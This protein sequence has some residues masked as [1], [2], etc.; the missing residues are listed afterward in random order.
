MLLVILT[1]L[2]QKKF[3]D[4]AN[5]LEYRPWPAESLAA[6][7]WP[8]WRSR[9]AAAARFF[10]LAWP[11]PSAGLA[12]SR[13][14]LAAA[15]WRLWRS[16]AAAAARFFRLTWPWPSAGP[17]QAGF[18]LLRPGRFGGAGLPLPILRRFLNTHYPLR[19]RGLFFEAPGRI[20][21]ETRRRWRSNLLHETVLPGYTIRCT[22]PGWR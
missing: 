2:F 20:R 1:S 5:F 13:V 10:R 9:A 8:L 15:P 4:G 17:L 7:P 21:S 14:F 22:P 6:A 19:C 3:G 16:R 11:W 12:A 18:S